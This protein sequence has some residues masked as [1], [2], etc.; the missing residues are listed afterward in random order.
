MSNYLN[1]DSLAPKFHRVLI[2]RLIC[3]P[4]CLNHLSKIN[5]LFNQSIVCHSSKMAQVEITNNQFIHT[6]DVD[7]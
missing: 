7:E 6:F 3:P 2:G 1:P 4:V 5:T